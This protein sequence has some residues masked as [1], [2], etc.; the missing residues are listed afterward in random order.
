MKEICPHCCFGRVTMEGEHPYK[1]NDNFK[2]CSHCNGTGLKQKGGKTMF[3]F[4]K[5]FKLIALFRD[6][7]TVY[8]EESIGDAPVPALLHRRVIGAII[9]VI[10]TALWVYFGLDTD[11]LNGHLAGITDS[12]DKIVSAG[13]VLYGI[14]QVIVGMIGA[15]IRNGK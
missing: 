8:K 11:I 10:G 7:V 12:I 4:L 14:V 13:L 5:Y 15:K 2:D 3:S 9:A 6:A 1:L